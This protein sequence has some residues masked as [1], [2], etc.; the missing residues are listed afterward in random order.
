[1]IFDIRSVEK[2]LLDYRIYNELGAFLK[3][4]M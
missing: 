2:L 1:M 4:K 3:A